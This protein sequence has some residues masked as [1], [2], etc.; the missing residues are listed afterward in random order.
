MARMN[1]SE[2]PG[3]QTGLTI[4]DRYQAGK[5]LSHLYTT[6]AAVRQRSSMQLDFSFP[7]AN[8]SQRSRLLSERLPQNEIF[9][10]VIPLCFSKFCPGFCRF[11]SRTS[12]AHVRIQRRGSCTRTEKIAAFFF[13]GKCGFHRISL[14]S[15]CLL[16]RSQVNLSHHFFFSLTCFKE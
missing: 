13:D 15:S 10:C 1:P 11:V 3:K 8:S 2:Y 9:L 16:R 12:V 4:Q 14:L 6:P 5:H 7:F